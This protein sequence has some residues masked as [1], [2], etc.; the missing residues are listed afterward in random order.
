MCQPFGNRNDEWFRYVVNDSGEREYQNIRR[1]RS[2]N[3]S[4]PELRHWWAKRAAEAAKHP[5]IDGIFIDKATDNNFELIDEDGDLTAGEGRV[6][7]YG[8]EYTRS[9]KHVSVRLNVQTNE[10]KLEWHD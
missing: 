5:S 3:H 10:A 8:Y 4:Y 1:Y 2:F 6:R 9:F 7:S